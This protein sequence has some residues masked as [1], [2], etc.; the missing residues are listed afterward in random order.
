[1]TFGK[2][3]TLALVVA[4]T[5]I[6][7]LA[8]A[9]EPIPTDRTKPHGMVRVGVSA[10][11]LPE[12]R[13]EFE[14]ST[15]STLEH[16]FGKSRLDIRHYSVEALTEAVRR[17]EVDVF[18]SSAGAARR[19]VGVGARPLATTVAPGLDDPN[20]NEGSAIVL[21]AD[22]ERTLNELRGTRVAANLPF[23]FSGYQIAL[24]EVARLGYDPDTFFRDAVFFHKS[25][26]MREV[27]EAV[28]DGRADVGILRL[29]AYE[30]FLETEPEL[31]RA[32]RVLPP[33]E[34]AA[35][36][37]AG[38]VA[39]RVSTRLYPAQGL[40]VMPTVSPDDSRRLLVGLLTMP[41]TPDGRAWSVATNFR[42]VDMLLKDLRVG[43]YAYLR[44]WTLRRFVETFW[45]A[46]VLFALGVVGL[47]LHSWRANILVKRREDEL[48]L[49]H[50][51]EE[52]QNKRIEQ[53]Q[54]AGAVGQLSNLIAHEAHQ[55]LAA[56]RLY[57]EGL[58]RQAA[59]PATTPKRIA[60]IAGRIAQQAERASQVVDRVRDYAK[61]RDPVMKAVRVDDIL[62]HLESTYPK[63]G[64][65]TEIVADD[66]VQTRFIKASLL[67]I[68]LAVVNLLRNAR[69][70]TRGCATP[71][72]RL[73]VRTVG[74]N[75]D[76]TVEDNGPGVSPER[77]RALAEPLSSEKPDGLGLG[78]SIVKHLVDRHGGVLLFAARQDPQSP[79][80]TGLSASIRLP[81]VPS[82][83]NT[84]YPHE[85]HDS[86]GN[87]T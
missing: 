60:S 10:F 13:N 51:R 25:A 20:H 78:L 74:K 24:G 76:F 61:Q 27:A 49:A 39:C 73:L 7:A 56:I 9:A 72:I 32:L 16:V 2:R 82:P 77:L 6:G 18:I 37:V 52:T 38:K 42:A 69:E 28:R 54:R 12:Q 40:S 58:E 53:L 36:E 68:E 65:M 48:A 11:A 44:Q 41:P 5:G 26:A 50:H 34:D 31:A 83:R 14:I 15:L 29:C 21:R 85:P 43:P 33:P 62:R 75:I 80:A 87:Q 63:L 57:A 30:S 1:M 71:R 70:A 23:G 35:D 66:A 45:P 55:P 81:I 79:D 47:V 4:L 86:V 8:S 59:N 84:Q 22:D 67:E 3:F 19:L 46:I 64:S 17:G